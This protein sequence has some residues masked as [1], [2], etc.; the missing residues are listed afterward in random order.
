VTDAHIPVLH[1][2]VHTDE[3][4]VEVETDH[5]VRVWHDE[6]GEWTF[7]DLRARIELTRQKSAWRIHTFSGTHP[8]ST[9]RICELTPVDEHTTDNE[10]K[11]PR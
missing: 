2:V 6:L 3:L 10:W 7:D 11:D 9:L 8:D 4:P 1:S 5:D